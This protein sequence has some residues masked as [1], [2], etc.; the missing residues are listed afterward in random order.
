MLPRELA[1]VSHRDGPLVA[2]SASGEVFPNL[3]A[4]TW[5]QEPWVWSRHIGIDFLF[6][7]IFFIGQWWY[8]EDNCKVRRVVQVYPRHFEKSHPNGLDFEA[9]HIRWLRLGD[10]LAGDTVFSFREVVSRT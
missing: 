2:M 6:H 3:E 7:L 1:R 4:W 10:S 5:K 8:G 9:G